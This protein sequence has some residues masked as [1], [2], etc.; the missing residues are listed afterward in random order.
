MTKNQKILIMVGAIVLVVITPF[1]TALMVKSMG[2]DNLGYSVSKKSGTYTVKDLDV[3]EEAT[4]GTN[5]S[6]E[7]GYLKSTVINTS[8]TTLET[9]GNVLYAN[10]TGSDINGCE[11]GVYNVIR[12]MADSQGGVDHDAEATTTMEIRVYLDDTAS[13]SQETSFEIWGKVDDAIVLTK[14]FE[15]D[16]GVIN[17][18]GSS[19]A[20]GGIEGRYWSNDGTVG[21]TSSCA[22]STAL[23][24]KNGLITA[25][26]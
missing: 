22:F 18:V 2:G 23:T 26:N 5:L 6:T 14:M 25:C 3:A 10:C 12:F 24:V 16:S 15:I 19:T 4:I 8:S 1:I 17:M 13:S 9:V 11:D 7:N 21:L 20:S